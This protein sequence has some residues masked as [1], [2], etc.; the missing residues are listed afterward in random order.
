MALGLGTAV[1]AF[2]VSLLVTVAV[3]LCTKRRPE[4]ELT[5]LTIT[6]AT[7]E[8]AQG[9]W[10]KRPEVIAAGVILLAAIAVNLIF[11]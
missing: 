6:L 1:F 10:W 8:K 11:L 9:T 2:V 4:A 7:T 3:S 5:G